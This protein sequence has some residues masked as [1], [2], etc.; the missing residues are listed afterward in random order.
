MTEN[1]TVLWSSALEKVRSE[2]DES[3]YDRWFSSLSLKSWQDGRVRLSVPSI[4][5]REW[6]ERHYLNFLEDVLHKV[7][8]HAIRVELE[9]N[10]RS[11]DK[12]Q[13]FNTEEKSLPEPGLTLNRRYVFDTFVIGES[14]KMTH[15]AAVGV[16]NAPAELYNPLFIYGGVGLGKTHITQAIGHHI[17]QHNRNMRVVY[18]PAE[19]FVNEFIDAIKRN[20]RLQFQ[21]RYRNVDVL[22][23]DDIEFLAGKESTQEEFFHTFNALHNAHKQI[24][25]SSDRPPKEI[26]TIEERLRSRFEWGLITEIKPPDLETR[27]AILRRKCEIDNIRLSDDVTLFIAKKIR[28][29]VREL[30]GALIRLAACATMSHEPITTELAARVLSEVFIEDDRDISIEKIQKRVAEQYRVKTSDILGDS[31]SRSVALPRRIAMYLTRVLTDHSFPEIGAHFGN[32]DHST[33]IHAC[34]RV[35][36]DMA[37]NEETRRNIEK[38]VESIKMSSY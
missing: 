27:V 18:M 13:S 20:D 28:S 37:K 9:V 8:G 25:L 38:L 6:L 33:V 26:P 21:Y 24:V 3:S 16:A 5:N 19:Q 23:I 17:R 12:N 14:N 31:R 34:K 10:G 35:E 32:K 4:H 11:T 30:E 1:H 15:A 36:Q 22:L 29:S 2:L 7:T